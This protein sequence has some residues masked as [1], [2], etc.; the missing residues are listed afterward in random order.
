MRATRRSSR[1]VVQR[2]YLHFS[3]SF[4]PWVLARPQ[5][6]NPRPPA[7]QL[8]ALPTEL[9]LPRS[10]SNNCVNILRNVMPHYITKQDFLRYN[11]F[12][13]YYGCMNT[14]KSRALIRGKLHHSQKARTWSTTYAY[15]LINHM[16]ITSLICIQWKSSRFLFPVSTVAARNAWEPNATSLLCPKYEEEKRLA[17]YDL[18][19]GNLE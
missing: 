8:H 17:D 6:S 3:L 12:T 7:L 2:K 13:S 18:V 5:E 4:R 14:R 1:L 10:R 9:T 16:L 15:H 11:I 19:L